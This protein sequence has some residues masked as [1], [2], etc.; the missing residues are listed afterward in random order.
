[1]TRFTAEDAARLEEWVQ[2]Y[3]EHP[4][5]DGPEVWTTDAVRTLLAV[6]REAEARCEE[7]IERESQRIWMIA[8][9]KLDDARRERDDAIQRSKNTAHVSATLHERLA[10][11]ATERD[12]LRASHERLV[13]AGKKVVDSIW[14][15]AT[16]YDAESIIYLRL[17]RAIHPIEAALRGAAPRLTTGGTEK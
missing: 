5:A 2:E 6:W 11:A 12:A 1:M 15:V 7:R 9:Q 3:T 17:C 4:S 16:E 13:E 8:T 10:I 14:D